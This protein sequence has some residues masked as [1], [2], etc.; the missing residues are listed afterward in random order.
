ML[1]FDS[2]FFP[3]ICSLFSEFYIKTNLPATFESLD[4]FNIWKNKKC[5]QTFLQ[6]FTRDAGRT[7]SHFISKNRG[8]RLIVV[9]TR[10]PK[11]KR[12][13]IQRSKRS[14][15]SLWG[16]LNSIL[17][18]FYV[19]ISIGLKDLEKVLVIYS[20]F[21]VR[22]ERWNFRFSKTEK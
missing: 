13:E 7:E 17:F 4:T 22:K 16:D 2:V 18:H 12:K 21:E 1:I 11:K 9:S 19:R 3:G 8:T 20:S 14:K 5:P 6:V 15:R 10:R